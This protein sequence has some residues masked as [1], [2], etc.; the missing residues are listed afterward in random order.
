MKQKVF[1]MVAHSQ[2]K[3]KPTDLARTLARS[4]GVDK[5]EVKSAISELTS[6]GKLIYSYAGHSWLEI[7]AEEE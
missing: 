2:K 4:L 5:H 7:P 1:E 3:L 6:E